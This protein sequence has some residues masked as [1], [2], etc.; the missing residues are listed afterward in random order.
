MLMFPMAIQ[1]LSNKEESNFCS[2]HTM[3]V[4]IHRMYII[5][6]IHNNDVLC[7]SQM[8]GC[9]VSDNRAAH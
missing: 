1:L 6:Y 9:M 8:S 7:S 3:E 2:F 4:C 5:I